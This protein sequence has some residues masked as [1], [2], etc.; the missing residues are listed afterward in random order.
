MAPA[1]QKPPPLPLM[2]NTLGNPL[3]LSGQGPKKPWH[4]SI[5]AVQP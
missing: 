2:Q 1:A 3:G 4:A 5:A